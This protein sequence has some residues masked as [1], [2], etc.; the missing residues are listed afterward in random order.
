MSCGR[1]WIAALKYS[2]LLVQN[3]IVFRALIFFLQFRSQFMVLLGL[4]SPPKLALLF[5]LG[6]YLSDY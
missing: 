3:Y 2:T 6:L 5:L 4:G 1:F